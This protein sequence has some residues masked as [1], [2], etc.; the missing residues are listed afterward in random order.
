M[1]GEVIERIAAH[2]AC[3]RCGHAQLGVLKADA[4]A[5]PVASVCTECGLSIAWRAYFEALHDEPR[6]LV[7]HAPMRRWPLAWLWSVVA[8]ML[9]ILTGPAGA[10]LWRQ[11]RLEHGVR[12]LR[13]VASLAVLLVVLWFA[14]ARSIVAQHGS[15][16]WVNLGPSF[17]GA[18]H[19]TGLVTDSIYIE[20]GRG[21]GYGPDIDPLTVPPG[22]Y[23]EFTFRP[24]TAF[25]EWTAWLPMVFLP[26]SG[27]PLGVRVPAELTGRVIQSP[28]TWRR[29]IWPLAETGGRGPRLLSETQ[30]E[31]MNF[32]LVVAQQSSNYTPRDTWRI[33]WQ[34][35]GY[36][37]VF[38]SLYG[39]GAALAFCLLPIARRRAKVRWAHAGRVGAYGILGPL[40]VVGLA[41]TLIGHVPNRAT[42]APPPFGIPL[43]SVIGHH[44]LFLLVVVVSTFL[45][46]WGAATR[47]LRMERGW[48][49]A[50]SV[51]AIATLV[52]MVSAAWE[53]TG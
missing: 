45:W 12:P 50:A 28:A 35:H 26:W 6:W 5:W 33:W 34:E 30:I 29:D 32:P 46:S 3:P 16:W 1:R 8:S 53:I 49:V 22:V 13:L 27:R 31:R 40:L 24:P 7:E 38:A 42:S 11:M 41:G 4:D 36:G 25:D 47:Y 44:G 9:A 20:G 52:A 15:G 48:A 10:P 43:G 39:V 14:V 23:A 51:T 19:P 2:A 17:V 37:V 18:A 21:L